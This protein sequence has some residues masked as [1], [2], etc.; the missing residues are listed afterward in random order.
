M[1]TH[2]YSL[3]LAINATLDMHNLNNEG[4]EGNQLQTRMVDIVG[5]DGNLYNVNAIS[6]DMLKHIQA[7]HLFNLARQRN[8]PLCAGCK[9]FNPN[10]INAD[11]DFITRTKG[12]TDVETL[13]ELLR[14]CA[15]DDLEGILITEGGRS[16]PR[17][18]VVEFGWAVGIPDITREGHNQ[19]FF[20]VKYATERSEG[21]RKEEAATRVQKGTGGDEGKTGGAN[22]GQ[23]IFHRPASSGKYAIVCHLEIGRIGY[24][25]IAQRYAISE[26]E[27]AER[28]RALLESVLHT[29][30]QLNGAMRSAQLPHLVAL[31]G[32]LA[33]STMLLPAPLISPITDDYRDQM[34]RV[35]RAVGGEQGIV[36][37]NFDS[38][39]HLAE[40]I[41]SLAQS[42]RPYALEPA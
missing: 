6:G 20:H 2:I 31:E 23:A 27:R 4:N 18:S 10:R 34:S 21:K 37:E 15:M 28:T 5:A 39:G 14:L 26:E 38:L 8:L 29:F 17:K 33:Y 1:T 35:A 16:I 3:A 19:S 40:Q 24:N 30:V 13:D 41:Q 7:E 42:A 22:L 36:V 11:Q 32:A 25:D 12:K 9:L